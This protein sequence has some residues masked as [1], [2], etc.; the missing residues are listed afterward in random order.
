LPSVIGR[1]RTRTPVGWCTALGHRRRG[2]D[3]PDLADAFRAH[4]V[5]VRIGLVEPVHL[6][7]ADVGPDRDVVLGE[8]VV[9][10]VAEPRIEH[11]LLLQGHRQPHRHAADELGAGGARV[12][13]PAGV[14]HAEHP[15][16]PDLARVGV[17]A[18]LGEQRAEREHRVVVGLGF[19]PGAGVHLVAV[20][21]V[22][23]EPLPER[24]SGRHQRRP[25]LDVPDEPPATDAVGWSL[26]PI[27]TSTSSVGTPRAS[28]ATCGGT[29]QAPVP[30]SAAPIRAT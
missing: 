29:V 16:H 13:D 12:D 7:V 15:G 25:Q 4:R 11:A 27:S 21:G 10:D 19:P 22:V 26:S 2:A 9:D 1:S 23:A 6:H 24:P 28:A 14:E 8:I 17:H 5:D 18:R 20:V 3:D 30:R